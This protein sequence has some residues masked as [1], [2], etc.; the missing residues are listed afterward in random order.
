M[1]GHAYEVVFLIGLLGMGR[2][3]L[4]MSITIMGWAL[5]CMRRESKL[6]TV[7]SRI[8]V[9]LFLTVGDM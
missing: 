3:T 8:P 1:T 7:Q 4:S 6:S 5:S 9:F 2:P